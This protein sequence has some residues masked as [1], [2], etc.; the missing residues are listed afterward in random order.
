[1]QLQSIAHGVFRLDKVQQ[2]YGA[3]R[4]HVE[5]LKLRGSSFREGFPRLQPSRPAA[6]RIFPRLIANEHDSTFP[7]ERVKS[8]LDALDIMFGGGIYRGSSTLLIGPTGVGKSTLAMQVA[9]TA[10]KRGDRAIVYAFDEVLRTARE[11]AESLGLAVGE[12]IKKGT[13]AMSQVDP[14]EL[15]PGEFIWRIKVDVEQKDTR[16]LVIDSLNG[17][18]NAMTGER[19]LTAATP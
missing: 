17:F 11:R 9:Y 2:S 12:E 10:A 3:T 16:V 1:M 8:G 19:G 15:S 18:L 6:S 5:I 7:L 4:R 13:L 14:A